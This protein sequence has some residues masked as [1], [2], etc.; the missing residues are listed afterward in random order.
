MMVRIRKVKNPK[1]SAS[2]RRAY[3][4]GR[5]VSPF[6]R[7]WF[8]FST[9]LFIRDYLAEIY[10][11]ADYVYSIFLKFKKSLA[12]WRE[13]R[14]RPRGFRR[15]SYQNFCNYFY[16]LRRLGLVEL[17]KTERAANPRSKMRL[18]GRS[19]YRIVPERKDD[20]AWANPRRALYPESWRG[21]K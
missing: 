9:S 16:W 19:Y 3:R 8:P 1:L 15:G 4:S 7:T 11:R 12:E 21:V 10:P 18:V 6:W 2:L 14:G 17:V 13:R 20:P 5:R